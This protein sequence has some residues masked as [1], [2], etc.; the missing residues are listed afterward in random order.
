MIWSKRLETTGM[1]KMDLKALQA[2]ALLKGT[3]KD[4]HDC[5]FIN[6][7]NPSHVV[8]IVAFV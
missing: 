5:L 6:A 3:N 1:A 8:T 7:V 2:G 4:Q